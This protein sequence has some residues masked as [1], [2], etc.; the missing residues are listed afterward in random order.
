MIESEIHPDLRQQYAK[1]LEI[2]AHLDAD[3]LRVVKNIIA[4]FPG[5][6]VVVTHNPRLLEAAGRVIEL[7]ADGSVASDRAH[8]AADVA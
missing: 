5:T 7:A 8:A 4:G 3:T 2:D 6:V 1:V